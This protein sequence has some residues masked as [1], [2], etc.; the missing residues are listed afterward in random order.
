MVTASTEERVL[1]LPNKKITVIILLVIFLLAGIGIRLI[2]FTDMPLDFA[3]TRQFHSLIMTRG[4]YYQMDTP[5]TRAMDQGIRDYGINAGNAE[6]SLEPP[7]LENLVAFTYSIIGGENIFVGR[8][9]SIFFWIIGGI[10]LFLMA[11]KLTSTNGAFA[12]LAVYLFNH[13]GVYASRSFQPEPMMIMFTLWALYFQVCWVKAGTLKNA[14]LAGAF[15]GI[16]ILVKAPMVFFTGIPFAALVLQK[17]FKN[18]VKNWQVYMM[19]GLAILP[20]VVYNLLS[21]TLGGQGTSLFEARFFP[22]LLLDVSWY[23][24]WLKMIKN[25][26]GQFPFVIGLFGF[27][28]IA[29]REDKFFYG[30]LLFSYLVYGFVFTYH[31]YTHNYYHLPLIP[32]LALGFGFVF[33]MFF[34]KIKELNTRWVGQV[35]VVVVMIFSLGLCLQRVRGSLV[36][37][38]YRPEQ[39]YWTT[40]GNKIDR[41]ASV[42]ALTQDYGYR[43]NYWGFINPKLWPNSADDLIK[44]LQGATDPEFEQLFKELTVG[45]NLFLVT[46]PNEFDNQPELKAY[47]FAHYPYEQGDSYYAFDLEH[48]LTLAN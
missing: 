48:P 27:F 34:E 15:T 45:R 28:L 18:W 14:I 11:R 12:A 42:I 35:L 40:L 37:S 44:N 47:L 2:D 38:D 21:A 16:A 29:K 36:A 41:N 26:V 25:V 22:Q 3:A 32:I 31:V 46:M 30:S 39:V 23:L 43:I 7:I 20:A 10:P 5:A 33:T 6:P 1:F 24:G 4:I 8:A 19:A 13:F 9:Y 17:G